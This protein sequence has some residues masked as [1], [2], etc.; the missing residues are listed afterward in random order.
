MEQGRQLAMEFADLAQRLQ[1][2]DFD[3]TLA[4][5][6][7]AAIDAVQADLGGVM[8]V[9]KGEAE[10]A[11]VSDDLVLEADRL[12][13]EAGDGPCLSAIDDLQSFIIHDTRTETRWPNWCEAVDKLGIRSVLSVALK[14]SSPGLLGA[15]NLYARTPGSFTEEDLVDGTIL[16]RHASVALAADKEREELRRAIDGRHMI[17]MAQGI[18]MERFDLDRDQAFAVLRRYSQD[19]NVKLREVASQLVESRALPS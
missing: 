9:R 14:S 8:L 11:A 4:E 13:H 16:A 3:M 12:Q 18:L 2:S 15:L 7:R 1:G 6:L 19:R 10:S 17:G 5:V